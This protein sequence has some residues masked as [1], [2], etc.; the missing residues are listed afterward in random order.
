MIITLTL[1]KTGSE[2]TLLVQRGDL[3]HLSQFAYSPET[4][5]TAVIQQALTALAVVE[6][7]PP[8][9]PDAPQRKTAPLPAASPEP[10]EPEIQVPTKSKKGTTAIPAR[11]LQITGG[12]TDE[13]AQE[14]ALKVAGR[15]LDSGL[16]DGKT[17]I[18]I[19]DAPAV[20][21][22]LDGLTDKELKVLFRLEQFVQLNPVVVADEID[23][24]QDDLAED[25]DAQDVPEIPETA[26]TSEQS[27]LI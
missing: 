15:L 19:D 20:L 6:N 18:G 26:G 9:N 27:A 13:A 8:V 23:S 12:E 25:Q 5:F 22:R 11:L 2:G 24:P 4:D 17:P 14:Q 7:D 10:P 1:P 16:W 3:A 21:R